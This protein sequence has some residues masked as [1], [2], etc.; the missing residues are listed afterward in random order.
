MN[1]LVSQD[2]ITVSLDTA[3]ASSPVIPWR[4]E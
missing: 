1:S 4:S 3:T 2:S